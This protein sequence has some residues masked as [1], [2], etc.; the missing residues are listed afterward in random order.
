M[1]PLLAPLQAHFAR[2]RLLRR[3]CLLVPPLAVLGAL[4]TLAFSQLVL[5]NIY[6]ERLATYG[7]AVFAR[8]VAVAAQGADTLRE[9]H[10]LS[11]Q[12][13]SDADLQELRY[14]VFDDDYLYDIGRIDGKRL[15][16][17]A[18][19]GRLS[20]PLALPPPTRHLDNGFTLW[21][22]TRDVTDPRLTIDMASDTSAIVFT[23]PTAFKDFGTPPEHYGALVLT[24][25]GTHI[26]RQFGATDGLH[27]ALLSPPRPGTLFNTRPIFRTCTAGLD[28]C[29][30]ATVSDV[31][32]L[33]LPVS[34]PAGLGGLGAMAASCLCL[35]VLRRG[36]SNLSLADQVRRA[37]AEGHLTMVYQPLVRIRDHRLVGAEAL[38]RL[39]DMR[40]E[41]LSPD[42]FIATA[43]RSGFIGT[44]TRRVIKITLTDLQDRLTAPEPF[45]VSINLSANDVV[46]TTLFDYIDARTQALGIAPERVVFEIT[47]RSTVDHTQLAA[48]IS[49]FHA[50][51]YRFYIDDF[52]TG[53]SSLAYLAELPISG[54]KI[55]KMFTSAIGKEAVSSTIVSE[56]CA[57]A[58]M[59]KVALIVEG[60]EE[61]DQAAY[62]RDLAPEAIGQGW[63]FGRP[64][65]AAQL[66]AAELVA[67]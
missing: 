35:A 23:A 62:I 38:A 43:E 56:I 45:Y 31:N 17:T 52:G 8:A 18:Y 27:A 61:E 42:V 11:A 5:Q 36:R 30:I 20:P 16:C 7:E 47:E 66:A 33:H 50:R 29:V 40:G 55:D 10:S 15:L 57:I 21:T 49:R 4:L 13:C 58:D 39:T 19:R 9:V 60:I 2:R 46:D 41:P 14:K 25:D 53:Y 26:Y 44:V 37:V 32:V 34:V 51:G 6:R 59:L 65:P 12:P 67:A 3:A 1:P 28:I 22:N 54:I 48:A 64:G 63:L 24:E